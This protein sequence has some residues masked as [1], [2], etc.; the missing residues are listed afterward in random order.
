VR[1]IV[2]GSGSSTANRKDQGLLKSIKSI[3]ANS[4]VLYLMIVNNPTSDIASREPRSPHG[5]R[6][7]PEEV[8]DWQEDPQLDYSYD[9][10]LSGERFHPRDR[11]DPTHDERYTT[12][13]YGRF[14]Q[15]V[16]PY[17]YQYQQNTPSSPPPRY[18]GIVTRRDTRPQN[19]DRND[20]KE[21]CVTGF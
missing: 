9:G 17:Q 4:D 1:G 13:N 2:N 15:Q 18:N 3:G 7:N 8:Y 16:V 10:A 5:T 21:Y 19:W 14:E 11:H 12:D 6:Q 20:D